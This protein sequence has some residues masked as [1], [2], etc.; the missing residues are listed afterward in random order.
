MTKSIQTVLTPLLIISYVSG[1]KIFEFPVGHPR[2]WFSLSYM[3]LF[4]SIYYFLNSTVIS[5]FINIHY[6]TELCYLICYWLDILLTLLSVVFGI[7]HDKKFRNCLKKLDIVDNTLLNVGTITDYH[8]LH[9][10]T[11]CLVL[12]WFLMIMLMNCGPAYWMK[13]EYNYDISTAMYILFIRNYCNYINMI[14]DLIVASI[15]GYIGLKFDQLNQ[16]LLNL[17]RA[18][19]RGIKRAW[20]NSMHQHRSSQTSSNE[21]M[22]WIVIHLHLELRKIS[23]EIDS[24]FGTQMTLKMGCNFCWLALD[25]RELFSVILINNHIKSNKILYIIMTIIWLCINV[26]KIFF[27]NYVCETISAKANATKYLIDKIPYSTYDVEVRENISQL[28]LQITRAP[29]G[30][31]GIGL[32]KFGYS[33]LYG[34]SSSITTVVVLLI[35]GYI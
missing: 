22:T 23:C 17:I 5:Y 20:G 21:W 28:L 29:I 10:K 31:Y 9:K 11:M 30:F 35:Q 6:T 15:L 18:N 32:F 1:L 26:L 33:F 24:I 16:H 4:W 7:Y 14:N 12:V 19:K 3:I 13:N 8:K 25:L 2:V 34:F 27:F